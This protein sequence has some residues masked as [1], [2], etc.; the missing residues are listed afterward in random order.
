MKGTR[1]H[2]KKALA[3]GGLVAR[4]DS[5][6]ESKVKVCEA[7]QWRSRSSG[8]YEQQKQKSTHGLPEIVSDNGTAFSSTEF[9]HFM[10][11]NG[12]RH[13][14]VPLITHLGHTSCHNRSTTS[15]APH[16]RRPRTLWTHVPDIIH[17]SQ[18]QKTETWIR[19]GGVLKFQCRSQLS[20]ERNDKEGTLEEKEGGSSPLPAP[21]NKRTLPEIEPDPLAEQERKMKDCEEK[22]ESED[23]MKC[24]RQG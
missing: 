5:E 18:R 11:H 17:R 7:C 15:T 4:E 10:K 8:L 13:I 21:I 12:I 14:R 23:V 3:R 19:S 9:G 24:R 16:G 2:Q 1:H 6:L 22:R 20:V